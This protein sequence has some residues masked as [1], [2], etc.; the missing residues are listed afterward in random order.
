MN[1]QKKYLVLLQVDAIQ[2]FLF[3]YLS[4]ET[5]K[6]TLAQAMENSNLVGK[7]T[8]L[9]QNDEALKFQFKRCLF[10]E[11]ELTDEK[12]VIDI[13]GK[14][15]VILTNDE[16]EKLE[17]NLKEMYSTYTNEG[18]TLV[19]LFEEIVNDEKESYDS[20]I[21]KSQTPKKQNK[22]LSLSEV[23]YNDLFSIVEE[24]NDRQTTKQL[25]ERYCQN[26]STDKYKKDKENLNQI[27]IIKA[28]L[29][30]IGAY[31]KNV[32]Y[33]ELKSK[34][35]AFEES[36]QSF[37][38]F[39][40]NK[41]FSLYVAGD[42]IFII[43]RI[44]QIKE[45]LTSIQSEL[46][47]INKKF[48]SK[49]TIAIAVLTTDYR[50]TFRYYLEKV[51]ELLK[52]AKQYKTKDIVNMNGM[53]LDID[54]S[55]LFLKMY[56]EKNTIKQKDIL[57]SRSKLHNTLE[58]IQ[59]DTAFKRLNAMYILSKDGRHPLYKQLFEKIE[60][61]DLRDVN[62]MVQ[63]KSEI[64]NI[65]LLSKYMDVEKGGYGKIQYTPIIQNVSLLNSS[66]IVEIF[67]NEGLKVHLQLKS[68]VK[69]IDNKGFWFRLNELVT[70]VQEIDE[71][72]KQL[73]KF[74]LNYQYQNQKIIRYDFQ[75]EQDRKNYY[76]G[77]E[78]KHREKRTEIRNY[79][80]CEIDDA[81]QNRNMFVESIIEEILAKSC[82]YQR[83]C[84]ERII[85][86]NVNKKDKY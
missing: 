12:I 60:K 43:S 54:A 2:T 58:I 81:I 31:F 4:K 75:T 37:A 7:I 83:L 24:E 42:D 28:D 40:K 86:I 3:E 34:A 59:G 26:Y 13:S 71:K 68:F 55:I 73:T 25:L 19:Y 45:V 39:S 15:I 85:D 80:E 32:Q 61:S 70:E 53:I 56:K 51:E 47:M 64:Q 63:I 35:S 36:I 38:Q 6:Q 22:L 21:E 17:A 14:C 8:K 84:R 10:S 18:L 23:L 46:K 79:K 62:Q 78:E 65:L 82:V 76:H 5:N 69:N 52:Q 30:N 49:L 16:K 77:G 74:L 11:I 33:S 44:D 20:L 27:A 29:N 9:N 1:N 66:T 72:K 67:N 48:D 57:H 50:S 41:I